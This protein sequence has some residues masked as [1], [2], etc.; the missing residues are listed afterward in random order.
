MK[1]RRT[2]VYHVGP[3]GAPWRNHWAQAWAIEL[4]ERVP[5]N[6]D[7]GTGAEQGIEPDPV[8]KARRAHESRRLRRARRWPKWRRS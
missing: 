1:R 5:G 3:D 6:E 7:A 4:A 8:L 2:G